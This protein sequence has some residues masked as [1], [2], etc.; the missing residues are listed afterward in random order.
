ME[1]Y[2]CMNSRVME[3][4]MFLSSPGSVCGATHTRT[5]MFHLTRCLQ[6]GTLD[7][8]Q[9]LATF[10]AFATLKIFVLGFT[11]SWDWVENMPY[12]SGMQMHDASFS[13]QESYIGKVKRIC[14]LNNAHYLDLFKEFFR[15]RKSFFKFFSWNWRKIS[16]YHGP[17][18]L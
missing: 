2:L 15:R 14:G 13:S 18:Y 4:C 10:E 16:F 8:V 6:A 1:S 7:Q 3:F 9:S 12:P 11:E 5:A 17:Q